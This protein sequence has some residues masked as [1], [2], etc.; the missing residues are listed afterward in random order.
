MEDRFKDRRPPLLG[1]LLAIA[2]PMVVSQASDTV[3]MF[4]DRLFLSRLGEA[5]LSAAMSGG[6]TAFM[7]SALFCLLYTSPSPRDS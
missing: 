7:V 5:Y 3:M 2:L 6:L 1:R 4:T